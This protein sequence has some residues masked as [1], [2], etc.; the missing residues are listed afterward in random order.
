M[1]R[2]EERGGTTTTTT[3]SH[4]VL[5]LRVGRNARERE[6]EMEPIDKLPELFLDSIFPSS[7]C[8]C[9]S[10][11]SPSSFCSCCS[12]KRCDRSTTQYLPS[13]SSGFF[14]PFPFS[15]PSLETDNNI[16]IDILFLSFFCRRRVL[17]VSKITSFSSSLYSLLLLLFSPWRQHLLLFLSFSSYSTSD[18]LFILSLVSID[19]YRR[20][21]PPPEKSFAFITRLD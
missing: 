16:S 6:R 3:P 7:L 21:T 15:I 1:K 9:C 18:D 19:A 20:L 8:C 4:C 13:T 17:P 11:F 5:S 10:S 12:R 14:F 2:R